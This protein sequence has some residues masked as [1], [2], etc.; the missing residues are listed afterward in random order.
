MLT[1]SHITAESIRE[2]YYRMASHSLDKS[3]WAGNGSAALGF[4]THMEVNPDD[5][6]LLSAVGKGAAKAMSLG[7][8]YHL[9]VADVEETQKE[10]DRP[11]VPGYDLTFSAPKSL[12]LAYLAHSDEKTKNAIALAHRLAVQDALSLI[13]AKAGFS[14]V[15]QDNVS[16]PI[17][18]EMVFAGFNHFTNR[19]IEPHLHAH[20]I[21]PNVI[22]CE[23]DQWR[24]LDSRDLYRWYMAAGAL[25]RSS[26]RE[27]LAVMS[28][29]KWVIGSDGWRAEIDG[30]AQWTSKDGDKLLTAYSTRNSQIE[31]LRLDLQSRYESG[32]I[33]PEVSRSL[34]VRT[35][36]AKDFADGDARIAEI[37]QE[38]AQQ[39]E[40][41]WHITPE[42]W[43]AIFVAYDEPVLPTPESG[44]W[45]QTPSHL[46]RYGNVPLEISSS[47]E[48]ADYL[49]KLL[50]SDGIGTTE[51]EGILVGKSYVSVPD[52]HA[53]AYNLLGGF[54]DFQMIEEAIGFVVRG[55]VSDPSL[56]LVPLVP[57]L[58]IAGKVV[59]P[60]KAPIRYYATR[61]VLNVEASILDI[62]RSQAAGGFVDTDKANAAIAQVILAQQEAGTWTLS[63]EQQN[64]IRHLLTSQTTITNLMGAQGSGKTTLFKHFSEIAKENS[65]NVWGLAPQGTAANRLGDT[66]RAIDHNAKSYTIES[67]V[68]QVT[69]GNLKIPQNTC[70]ILDESSQAD[71]LE[72]AEVAQII[73][74]AGA[75]LILVGDDRQLGSVRYGGM[76]ATLFAQVG[77]ARLTVTRRADDALD[78]T[79]QAYLR[80]GD[81]KQALRIYDQAGR[82]TVAQDELAVVTKVVDW[83]NAEFHA[84]S[85]C[86]AVTNS[87][88]EEIAAN[89]VAQRLWASHREKWLNEYLKSE[90]SHYRMSEK[91]ANRRKEKF[92]ANPTVTINFDGNRVDLHMGDLVAVR[93]SAYLGSGARLTNGQRGHIVDITADNIKVLIVEGST[94]R[95]VNI[96]KSDLVDKS[97]LSLGWAS[98]VFRTQSMEL[99]YSDDAELQMLGKVSLDVGM[100]ATANKLVHGNSKDF[101]GVI[102][103]IK[104]NDVSMYCNDGV[105]RSFPK[106]RVVV[107]EE[108]LKKASSI[109][110][111]AVDGSV[112]M[113]GTEGMNLDAF[114]V[115]ASRAKTRTEMLFRSIEQTESDLVSEFKLNKAESAT[116]PDTFSYDDEGEEQDAGQKKEA[117]IVRDTL[118]LYLARQSR[119]EAPDSAHLA[120]AYE[121]E[122]LTL[123]TTIPIE[124]LRAAQTWVADN[125]QSGILQ[126][127]VDT[128]KA[129]QERDT[130]IARR[131]KLEAQ[132]ATCEDERM[133]VSL[134]ARIEECAAKES[135][136][137]HELVQ[138]EVFKGFLTHAKDALT[139]SEG[140]VVIDQRYIRNRLEIIRD[141]IAMAETSSEWVEV[142]EA[143][144]V[145][146]PENTAREVVDTS[147]EQEVSLDSSAKLFSHTTYG[148]ASDWMRLASSLYEKMLA[149]CSDVDAVVASLN[150]NDAD[151][152]RM[153]EAV[154]TV[155]AMRRNIDPTIHRVT[156]KAVSEEI[157]SDGISADLKAQVAT[158]TESLAEKHAR[159]S[160]IKSM[161]DES[162]AFADDDAWYDEDY[163][164]DVSDEEYASIVSQRNEAPSTESESMPLVNADAGVVEQSS[165]VS[166]PEEAN[167]EASEPTPV[168]TDTSGEVTLPDGFPIDEWWT[169]GYLRRERSKILTWIEWAISEYHDE[170]VKSRI[171]PTP[172]N[173][174]ARAEQDPAFV[175]KRN[176]LRDDFNAKAAIRNNLVEDFHLTREQ[177]YLIDEIVSGD[178]DTTVAN[179]GNDQNYRTSP[180]ASQA[181]QQQQ[182]QSRGFGLGLHFE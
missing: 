58:H 124:K 81:L 86:M 171:A 156:M 104:G 126:L 163:E 118:M 42:V 96:P 148:V 51:S 22:K 91:E 37:S 40:E 1:V 179:S 142:G 79:A 169:A 149:D 177:A 71:T 85:D 29:A 173:L 36:K 141:A 23:D 167:V 63:E 145:P 157:L 108:A 109:T 66:L 162:G 77:G 154:A 168:D 180:S 135:Y 153:R 54:V 165:D 12:S 26:L 131:L 178:S 125:F 25:Y 115:G 89:L 73:K 38:I 47:S 34:A 43:K 152:L 94:A 98:T 18:G 143:I 80:M 70:I 53:A 83:F 159:Q 44:I 72:L 82:I 119:A 99:G 111:H 136:A 7:L 92:V 105:F 64:A 133:Q 69:F 20:V 60:A 161:N 30:L 24:S 11:R 114:L 74:D 181:E 17:K 41:V 56:E 6:Y 134:L 19:N 155:A 182:R 84:G 13:E 5:L 123:A 87:R 113:I 138:F 2:Y 176:R 31:A 76:F 39:L 48:L 28:N 33:P 97:L 127:S 120:L 100:P 110:R 9:S 151:A 140:Q 61:K 15:T 137:N 78:R 139:N 8:K 88:Q 50:F 55:Q 90:M 65:I 160:Y 144:D 147:S 21:V 68:W 35:R 10:L 32:V 103:E 102:H 59:K 166:R 106:W 146:L 121:R 67:F 164:F 4:T 170:L 52:I 129:T 27:H 117:S 158:V 57:A 132:L 130:S 49:S 174:T 75:K 16:S 62:A 175:A 128:D 93:K 172:E 122:A 112:L 101:S 14:R 45:L 150:F 116:E 46:F 3:Y 95:H 107:D